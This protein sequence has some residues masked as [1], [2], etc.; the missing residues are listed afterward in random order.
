MLKIRIVKFKLKEVGLFPHVS[1]AGYH[2][3]DEDREC[4]D[5]ETRA[6]QSR[7]IGESKQMKIRI[8]KSLYPK[9]E[10][11]DAEEVAKVII[12]SSEK[13][14]LLLKRAE[15]MKSNPNKWDLP[16]GH[17]KQNEEIED[18]AR[19][20]V[21]EEL[22]IDIEDLS[23]V[24]EFNKITIYKTSKEKQNKYKLDDENQEA[25]WVSSKELENLD[26]VSKLKKYIK[27]AI[28]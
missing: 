10:E 23:K 27:D 24:D 3:V 7:V 17:R 4:E 8:K 22:G 2:D 25:R 6:T 11:D 5:C 26:I 12:V 18:A 20:E 21:K 13:E 1:F 19:R 15:H 9:G 16:G 28:A 14:I